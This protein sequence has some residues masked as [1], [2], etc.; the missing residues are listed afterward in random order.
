MGQLGR[1]GNVKWAQLHRESADSEDGGGGLVDGSDRGGLRA[2]ASA[3]R[4]GPQSPTLTGSYSATPFLLLFFLYI[5]STGPS[6]GL[7]F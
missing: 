7:S 2:V 6:E 5:K 1:R 4:P 3:V